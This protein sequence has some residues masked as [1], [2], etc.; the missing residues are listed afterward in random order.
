MNIDL[1]RE[2]ADRKQHAEGQN[3]KI[4]WDIPPQQVVN[5]AQNEIYRPM[6]ANLA[7]AYKND[8]TQFIADQASPFYPVTDLHFSYR[9]FNERLMFDIP[10]TLRGKDEMP[11]RVDPNGSKLINV[12]LTGRALC[13]YLSNV[14]MSQT[15]R[16]FGSVQGWRNYVVK[17]LTHLLLLD[18]EKAVATLVQ[19]IA[20][21]ASGFSATVS[22]LWTAANADILG[23]MATAEDKAMAELDTLVFNQNIYRLLQRHPA[24]TGS[25]V[26]SGGVMNALNPTVGLQFLK[27]YFGMDNIV[28]AKA[29]YNTTPATVSTTATLDY[30]WDDT[31]ALIRAKPSPG[32]P[33]M[34]T[35]FCRTFVLESQQIPNYRGF[36]VKSIP[37][38]TSF[39]GGEILMVGYFST[40]KVYAQKAGYHLTVK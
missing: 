37:E 13:A 18:R 21:Y 30:I 31:V 14:D 20:N 29:K 2:A 22:P 17:F 12:D 11:G 15:E 19:S 28:V 6:E 39:A 36:G 33:D 25:A 9:E 24:I 8:M 32:G 23:D 40:E 3:V 26:T 7:W 1:L 5:F 34:E 35:P 4:L 27:N 16:Q 38:N 10:A